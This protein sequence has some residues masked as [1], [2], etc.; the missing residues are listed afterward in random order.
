MRAASVAHKFR[1]ILD[2]KKTVER[3]PESEAGEDSAAGHKLYS[4]QRIINHYLG[5]R[6]PSCGNSILEQPQ[7]T[8]QSQARK[9]RSVDVL[10]I[11]PPPVYYRPQRDIYD[12]V[13]RL[14]RSSSR[15][16]KVLGEQQREAERHRLSRSR[17]VPQARYA[18]LAVPD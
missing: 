11:K 16:Q 8:S 14:T 13:A 3:E 17:T 5:N 6:T 2:Y 10:K 12:I 18:K 15:V 4:V 1:G 7:R 9:R